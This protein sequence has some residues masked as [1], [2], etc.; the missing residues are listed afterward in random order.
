MNWRGEMFGAVPGAEVGGGGVGFGAADV[1]GVGGVAADDSVGGAMR[2]EGFLGAEG[3]I[4]EDLG[5]MVR[6]DSFSGERVGV[7][8]F[9][10]CSAR[11][12]ARVLRLRGSTA[13]VVGVTRGA[14][15]F[16]GRVDAWRCFLPSR[17]RSSRCAIGGFSETLGAWIDYRDQARE[18]RRRSARSWMARRELRAAPSCQ[19]TMWL[20]WSPMK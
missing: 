17:L 11:L 9:F 8:R 14:R 18:T 10:S 5:A 7:R 13:P 2:A 19:A 20:T 3:R 15:P 1:G 16:L 4:E 6:R 12:A